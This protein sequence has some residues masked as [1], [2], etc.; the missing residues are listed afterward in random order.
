MP[1][2]VSTSRPAEEDAGDLLRRINRAWL[3]GRPRDLLGFFHPDIVM[4]YPGFAGRAQGREELVNGFVEFCENARVHAFEEQEHQ[5]DVVG[6][7]AV[8]SYAFTML[9]EREG[10]RYRSTGRDLWVF[11]REGTEWLAIWRTMLD[12]TDEPAGR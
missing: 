10:E 5:I 2:P 6:P 11:A 12:L 1:G 4:Q 8:A 9:Y 7:T 3:E